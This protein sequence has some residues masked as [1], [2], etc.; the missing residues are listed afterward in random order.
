LRA[1]SYRPRGLLDYVYCR[2]DTK[3]KIVT[4][5][6]FVAGYKLKRFFKL[7]H[8]YSDSLLFVSTP[9]TRRYQSS[10]MA[11]ASSSLASDEGSDSACTDIASLCSTLLALLALAIASILCALLGGGHFAGLACP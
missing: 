6:V 1:S 3:E 8:S 9:Y 10:R 7:D 4:W 2:S 5:S 11:Q